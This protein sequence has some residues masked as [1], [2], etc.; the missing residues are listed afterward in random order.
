MLLRA[1]E[2]TVAGHIWPTGHYLPI[3]GIVKTF[4]IIS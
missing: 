1:I 3:P 2:N 4:G